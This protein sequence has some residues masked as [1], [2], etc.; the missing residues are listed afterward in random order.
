MS[1]RMLAKWCIA[2]VGGIVLTGCASAPA[3]GPRRQEDQIPRLTALYDKANEVH[4]NRFRKPYRDERGRVLRDMS[5]ECDRLLAETK[6]WDSSARLTAAGPE[7]RNEIRANVTAFRSSLE[8]LRAAAD[9]ADLDSVDAAY[10]STLAAY[11][12]IQKE[13]DTTA[14]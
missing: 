8:G 9:K 1:I 11:S 10:S 12:R 2:C 3:A 6:S 13:L 14:P 4:V 7:K 5:A